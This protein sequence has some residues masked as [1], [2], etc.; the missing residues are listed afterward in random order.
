MFV[1]AVD[2]G[3]ASTSFNLPSG[4]SR[5][6]IF[7]SNTAIS[8]VHSYPS[9]TRFTRKEQDSL[10]TKACSGAFDTSSLGR[11]DSFELN[12][13]DTSAVMLLFFASLCKHTGTHHPALLPET[14]CTSKSI[15]ISSTH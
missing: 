7:G 4:L 13:D 5:I 15:C 3:G 10:A 11:L 9:S 1:G 6:G 14:N 8:S 12:Q 2:D